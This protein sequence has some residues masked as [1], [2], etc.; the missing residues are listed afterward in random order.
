VLKAMGVSPAYIDGA[1]R[2][3]LSSENSIDDMDKTI[4]ALKEIVPIISIKRG[5]KR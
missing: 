5:G 4:N 2:F 3:S 1:I